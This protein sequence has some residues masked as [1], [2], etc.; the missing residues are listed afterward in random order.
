MHIDVEALFEAGRARR[1]GWRRMPAVATEAMVAT[2]HPSAT[3][4]G[5]RSL[6]RGGNA[7]DAALAAAAILAVAEPTENGIGGDA[8]ALV[9]DRG[10]LYGLNGSGRSPADLGGR[11][12]TDDGPCSV[13]V[14]GAVR[15]WDDLAT[16][17]GRFGLDQAIGLA[18]ELAE[19]GLACSA[20]ISHK[21]SQAPLAPWRAPRLGE[22]YSLPELGATLRMIE[23]NGPAALYEG[24]VAAAIAAACW[25]SEADLLAHRS[26]WVEPLRRAYRGIE[27]CELPPNG[28]GAAA[29]LA[30]ALYEGLE[31]GEHSAIEAMKLGLTDTRAVVNDAPLPTD[32]FDETRLAARRALVRADSV[33]AGGLDLPRGG[34]TYLSVVDGDGMAVSLIQ[35]LYGRFG[36]GVVAPGTGI[37][38]Q[39]R[40]AGFS[41]ASD[42]PNALA[43]GRRPFHTIIPGMLLEGGELLGPFGVMGGPMQAQGHVQVVCNLVDLGDDPQAA[44]DAPRWRVEDDGSV[45]LE[46]GLEHIARD[47][48]ARGHAVR[49]E[50]DP[51]GFGVGQIILRHGGALIGG[52]DGRGDGYAAGI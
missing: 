28:Q 49:V 39:N 27:V 12:A 14:P 41:R 35:S 1:S 22:R 21:W 15:L 17:F 46:P 44:L 42:H 16:R 52:S 13:T 40:G 7:V 34:T 30:L 43:P 37:V 51:H 31:P 38:L 11:A 26:E 24:E 3:R 25:L 9:W 4:A 29:L 33:I 47:L 10:V 18:A 50:S 6:E 32:F 5:L 23:S 19:V 45:A 8:F 2:S 36:S 48:K 20:R